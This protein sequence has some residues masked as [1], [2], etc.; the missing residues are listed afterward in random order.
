MPK[1]VVPSDCG[2]LADLIFVYFSR[3]RGQEQLEDVELRKQ[4]RRSLDF[5]RDVPEDA[6]FV[7]FDIL[8]EH[9]WDNDDTQTIR[10]ATD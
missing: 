7:D 5:L 9:Q 6:R 2:A 8:E 4:L 10:A 3:H 1:Y